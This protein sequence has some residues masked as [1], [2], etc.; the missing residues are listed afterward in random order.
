MTEKIYSRILNTISININ[1]GFFVYET[2]QEDCLQKISVLKIKWAI[3]KRLNLSKA[4]GQ[5]F[6]LLFISSLPNL[7]TAKN[8]LLLK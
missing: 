5:N 1:F 7:V 4:V 8:Q 6:G 2:L 3:T